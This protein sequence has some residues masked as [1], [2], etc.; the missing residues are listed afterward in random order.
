M[1]YVDRAVGSLASSLPPGT[2]LVLY[3]DHSSKIENP[4][5]GYRGATVDD[6]GLV[7]FLVYD[8]ERNLR[9]AQKTREDPVVQGGHLTLLDAMTFLH[10]SIEY[11]FGKHP[12]ES[13]SSA[14]DGDAGP[15]GMDGGMVP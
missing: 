5:L 13:M 9:E 11:T 14:W 2:T 6:V 3:G 8:P 4:S 1:N 12:K 7:P 15:V 10:Q